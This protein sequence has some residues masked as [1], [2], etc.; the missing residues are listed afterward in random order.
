MRTHILRFAILA[1]LFS[2]GLALGED[3]KPEKPVKKPDLSGQIEAVS[4]D[5]KS[6]TLAIPPKVKGDDPTRIEVKINDKTKLTYFG[7]EANGENPTVGYVALVWLVEGS[8]DT[9][10]SVKLGLK[11]GG[12]KGPDFHGIITAVSK[13]AKTITVEIPPEEKGGESKKI[14]VKLT[15]KTK[16][17]YFGV[18]ATGEM[19]TVGY[20]ILVWLRDGSKDTAAGV[21][22]G[23]KN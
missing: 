21:R 13:D 18:G 11:D 15:D 7:V 2:T 22:L 19:P 8:Q 14:E 10:A 9:A 12:G 20:V 23:V 1:S 16:T 3:K 4:D 5:G 6:I 17:S